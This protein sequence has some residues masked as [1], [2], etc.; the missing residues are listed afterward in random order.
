MALTQYRI[1]S[2]SGIHQGWNE[3][4]LESSSSPDAC[5]METGEGDLSV[6]SGYVHHLDVPL[7]TGEPIRRLFVWNRAA[8][9]TDIARSMLSRKPRG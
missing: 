9:T 7:P 6:A 1:D 4:T 2:F 3:N 8:G 5:N